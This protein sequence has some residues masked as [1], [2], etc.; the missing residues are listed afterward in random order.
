MTE[1]EILK[2]KSSYQNIAKKL[3]DYKRM[4]NR[5]EELKSIE[6]VKEYIELE[7][8]CFK[9]Q[10]NLPL[11]KIALNEFERQ[12]ITT[13]ESNNI[14]VYMGEYDENERFLSYCTGLGNLCKYRDLE[15]FKEYRVPSEERSKFENTNKVVYLEKIEYERF[16]DPQCA[17]ESSFRNL[18]NS[19]FNYLINEPQ[20]VAVQKILKRK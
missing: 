14:L 20:E 17:V 1:N 10:N 12:S 9:A 15:N 4:R 3:E 16:L 2:A 7:K 11:E 8:I 18:R 5:L 19:F 13:C 6:V